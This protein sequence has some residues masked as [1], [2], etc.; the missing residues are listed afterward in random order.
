[1]RYT[2]VMLLALGLAGEHAGAQVMPASPA[3]VALS[4]SGVPQAKDIQGKVKA[5]DRAKKTVTL[6]DGTTLTI[7]TAVQV[8]PMALQTGAIIT[9]NYEVQDGQKVIIALDVW[10]PSKL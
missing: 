5:L 1:M 2:V 7:P 4:D 8:M 3:P 9:A 10:P 6:E